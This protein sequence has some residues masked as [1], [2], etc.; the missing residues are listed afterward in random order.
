MV[1]STRNVLVVRKRILDTTEI[2]KIRF[3]PD[4][5]NITMKILN[6]PVRNQKS[7]IIII[8]KNDENTI[9]KDVCLLTV[10]SGVKIT[11]TTNATVKPNAEP[12]RTVLC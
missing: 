12:V 10:N 3:E 4:V 1:I 9:R 8:L 5:K 7:T 2:I 6:W 11:P